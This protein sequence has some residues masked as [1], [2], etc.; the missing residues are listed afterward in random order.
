MIVLDEPSMGLDPQTRQVVFEMIEL[1]NHEGKTIL[2]VEQNARAGLKLSS[3]GDRARERDRPAA[4]LWTRG[5]RAPGDRRAVPR[6]RGVERLARDGA[7]TGPEPAEADPT[8]TRMRSA[9]T[10]RDV[11]RVAKV[12][13]GTVSRALNAQTRALVNEETAERVLQAARGARLPPEP[14][15]AR[16]EDEPL[17]HDRRAHPRHHEPAVPADPAR[18]RGPARRGRLHL[19]DRQHRQRPRARA[20]PPRGDA[21]SSGRRVHLR[22][23]AARPRAARRDRGRR[24]AA[25]RAR[26]P[27]PRGRRPCRR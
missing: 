21:R 2:L 14:D 7:M 13:P 16:A 24:R 22:D 5:A 3:R 11:A 18:D 23:G 25:A 19:A 8:M 12:H 27:Q 1:M 4:G 9:V 6:R 26:Q 10:I 20:Q 17:V 15:R